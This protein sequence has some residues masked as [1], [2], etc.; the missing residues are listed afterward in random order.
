WFI[1][2]VL[3]AYSRRRLL[4]E[5]HYW[6]L[7]GFPHYWVH[8]LEATD[9]NDVER[10][11]NQLRLRAAYGEGVFNDWNP[12]AW[13][14]VREQLGAEVAEGLA[15][16]G[17]DAL[18]ELTDADRL[19]AF[20]RQVLG[21]PFASGLSGLVRNW[22]APIDRQ[23]E[24]HFSLEQRQW[25]QHWQQHAASYGEVLPVSQF[26]ADLPRVTHRLRFESEASQ[27]VDVLYSV[28]IDGPEPSSDLT[29]RLRYASLPPMNAEVPED[30][31]L[32]V[33]HSGQRVAERAVP[34]SFAEGDRVLITAAVEWPPM[35]CELISGWERRTVE[36]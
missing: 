35:G 21:G 30:E 36:R 11:L 28:E 32:E 17:L 2:E 22:E 12:E 19:Q 3:I 7:D 13:L 25:K 27:T 29:W 18:E 31:I 9:E 5:D 1:R 33:R 20:L 26:L 10:R 6:I 16:A 4:L 24:T 23:L 14:R 15:W 34:E 8:A